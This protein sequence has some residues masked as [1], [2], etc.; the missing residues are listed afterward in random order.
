MTLFQV[1]HH[2]LIANNRALDGGPT[3]GLNLGDGHAI[4]FT[5]TTE[6][7]NYFDCTGSFGGILNILAGGS[8]TPTISGNLS[9]IDNSVV[10]TVN[11]MGHH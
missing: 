2:V 5:N 7:N 6:T 10:D 1:D 9:L 11:C 8:G 3:A 4:V